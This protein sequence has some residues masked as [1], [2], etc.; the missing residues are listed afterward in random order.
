MSVKN[1]IVVSKTNRKA[2]VIEV[3]E[4]GSRRTRHLKKVNGD[5]TKAKI[6]SEG[7]KV[8]QVSYTV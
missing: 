3:L 1:V 8:S 6:T 4:D 5:W 7:K 2:E